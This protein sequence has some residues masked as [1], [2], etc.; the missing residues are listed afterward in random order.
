MRLA[1][2]KMR[3]FTLI[4]LLVVIAIIAIL[5]G[6]LTPVVRSARDRARLAVGA[7]NQRQLVLGVGLY[8]ADNDS[9]LPPSTIQPQWG[10]PWLQN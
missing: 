4:E 1:V 2:S 6:I 5:T 8:A 3:G 9:R 10:L 7:S